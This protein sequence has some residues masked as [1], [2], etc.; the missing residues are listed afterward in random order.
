MRENS[1]LACALRTSTID[2]AVL[3]QKSC[4]RRRAAVVGFRFK[5]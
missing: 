2:E 4:G 3:V 5:T 1:G